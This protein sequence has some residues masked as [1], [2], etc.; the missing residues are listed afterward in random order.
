L[1]DLNSRNEKKAVKQISDIQMNVQLGDLGWQT[2]GK[3]KE[4]IILQ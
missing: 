1:F 3:P 2:N 4:A